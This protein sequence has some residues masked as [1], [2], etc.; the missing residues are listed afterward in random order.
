MI[1]KAYQVNNVVQE[2]HGMMFNFAHGIQGSVS[3]MA[4]GKQINGLLKAMNCFLSFSAF[5]L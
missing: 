1:F 3:F 5:D 4:T 2:A